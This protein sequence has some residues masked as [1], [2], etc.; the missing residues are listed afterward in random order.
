MKQVLLVTATKTKTL[1]EFQQRPIAQSL[2]ILC[3]KRYDKLE[4]DFEVVK[5]NSTGLSEVYNRY[6]TESNKDK[7]LLFVHDD[8][9][10]HDLN[11]VEKLNESPWDITGLAGISEYK[12]QDKN[13]WHL[14]GPREKMSGSVTHP[15]AFQNGNQIEV[16]NSKRLSTLFGPWPQ[17]CLVLDA[18]FLSIDV[19]KALNAGFNF[20][21]RHKFHHWDIASCLIANE[22]KLKMGTYPIFVVHHGLGNSYLSQDWEESNEIFKKNWQNALKTN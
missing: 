11:L 9:E 20:D 3:D 1:Q 2:K 10:I 15:L 7:I 12:L 21:E 4:F 14:G 18:L 5:D 17:R 16:D 19:E 22:K 8:V 13:L 6:L